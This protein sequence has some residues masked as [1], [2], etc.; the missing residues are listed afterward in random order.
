MMNEIKCLVNGGARLVNWPL[1]CGL[2]CLS[3]ARVAPAADSLYESDYPVSY[4]IP[5]DYPPNIH[6]TNF[7]ND[8][9]S[10]TVNFDTYG[11]T[12]DTI[13]NYMFEPWNTVNYTNNGS[14]ITDTGFR[15]DTQVTNSFGDS[16]YLMAGNFYNPGTI[17]CAS[18]TGTLLLGVA[19]ECLVTATNISMPGGTVDVGM[20]GGTTGGLI[21][22]VGQNV[23]L[24]RSAVTLEG[25]EL[26]SSE[27]GS[28]QAI[29]NAPLSLLY[30]AGFGLDTNQDWD[31]SIDLTATYALPS[32]VRMGTAGNYVW[33]DSPGFPSYPATTT[34]YVSV[35]QANT[36]DIIY[37][38]AFVGN[39]V[40]NVTPNVYLY[41]ES[42]GNSIAEVE[43]VG[44]YINPATGL[45]ANNYLYFEDDYAL[46]A[47][48]TALTAGTGIPDNFDFIPSSTSLEAGVL[49]DVSSFLALTDGAMTNDYSYVD[50]E[51]LPTTVPTNSVTLNTNDY[52][53]V[54][55][56]KILIS[57]SGSLDLRQAQ[58]SG[59]NYLSVSAPNQLNGSAGANISSAYSDINVGVANGN[60]LATN[61]LEPGVP[62]WNGTVQAWST[63]WFDYTTNSV[64]TYT[65]VTTPVST[66]SY[67]VTND[68]NVVIVVNQATPTT[69][70]EV[71]NLFLHGTNNIVVSDIYNILNGLSLDCAGLTLTA[72]G[73]G[74]QTP[75]GELNLQD[76]PVNWASATP[77]LRYLTNNGD[78]LLPLTGVNSLGLFGSAPAP[79]G[80]LINNDNGLISDQGSLVWAGNF[81]NSGQFY[82]GVGP[83]TLQ[84]QTATLTG[85][86]AGGYLYAGGDVSIA[87]SNL[88][89]GDYL[90][91]EADR[92]LTIIATNRL[93]DTGVTDGSIWYVGLS[94][95]GNGIKVP[96]KPSGGGGA[97]G[98]SLLGTSINLYAPS[99]RI[100]A[101][102][103]AGTDYGASPAG[104]TNNLA[105]G[106]LILDSLDANSAFA[107]NGA[108]TSNAIYVDQLQLLGFSDS[109]SRIVNT[110]TGSVSIPGLMINTNLVIYYADAVSDG[111]DVS[112][113]LNGFNTNHLRWVP[114]YVG[115]FSSTNLVYDGVTNTVN[116]ALAE[117]TRID[118]DGDGIP[119]AY[120]PTPFFL[121]VEVNLKTYLTNA[122]TKVAIT[123]DSIPNATNSVL[124]TTN[125]AMPSL[126]WTV[127][128]NFLSPIPY[129]SPPTNVTVLD[130]VTSPPRYYR[131][132]VNPWLT[133]PYSF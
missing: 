79:Y 106:Q 46:G 14:M 110:N 84:S 94:S 76:S 41:P 74:A 130:S 109:N 49:P 3:L 47:A 2:L 90:L 127:L 13:Q 120:D 28:V 23:D 10:F 113:K 30:Y 40:S 1:L 68:Y 36:N 52:L 100:V 55:P 93:A 15:F 53:A 128:T 56:D 45:P 44:S 119:N 18:L 92:S 124:Y 97:Y 69:P 86:F 122:N 12:F 21:A 37:T 25:S 9:N 111:A 103:W 8:A 88:L 5:P 22:F 19:G 66:N 96:V 4:T 16:V 39:T 42:G 91:L 11:I 95:I 26:G 105:V 7:V 82:N 117:N 6:A 61:L 104:F 116:V 126:P 29:P 98:N 123:W 89:A 59:Q 131:V 75:Y 115:Y 34:P 77:Q 72:N 99:N 78:I 58:I 81:V 101:N 54:L 133:Y 85:G 20:G 83:F 65:N 60:L 87:T 17:T 43:F 33:E 27:L 51:C 31:P 132:I 102:V 64:I 114:A 71:W 73:A 57:A 108:G 63:R 70:T 38:Y 107:F 24:S 80:A 35:L 118:S 125:I 121:P 129:P 32:W 67:R 48:K 50:V 62:A 112:F